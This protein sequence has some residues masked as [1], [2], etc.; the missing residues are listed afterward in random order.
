MEISRILGI[1]HGTVRRYAA[2]AEFPERAPHRRQRSILDPY[3]AHLEGRHADGCENALQLWRDIR[4]LGYT[5]TSTQV[6][7]WLQ[8]RRQ[9]PARTTPHQ[10]RVQDQPPVRADEP[11][12]GDV[13]AHVRPVV[14]EGTMSPTPPAVSLPSPRQLAWLL[15]RPADDLPDSDRRMLQ[16]LTQDR[17]AAR[18]VSFV[19]R[20]VALIRGRVADPE[21]ARA[22]FDVWL[23][24]TR[25]CG[26]RAVET[27]ARR[28]TQDGAAVRAALT[29]PWS[30]GQNGSSGH[31]ARAPQ[32]ANV[33]PRQ[34][35]LAPAPRPPGRLIHGKCGRP[36]KPGAVLARV[37]LSFARDACNAA[38]SAS[39]ALR[40]SNNALTNAT[41]ASGPRAHTASIS[42]RVIVVGTRHSKLRETHPPDKSRQRAQAHP[43]LRGT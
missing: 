37:G 8:Q 10:Y 3:L 7:R 41:I 34:L 5:G 30:N 15:V 1:A 20:F 14:S 13:P 39:S 26:I 21:G 33:R 28:L 11:W 43:A 29:T 18:V 25:T 17:E 12:S 16:Q 19:Q 35:R 38:I 31:E 9:R 36:G 40:R 23:D 27:F 32:T 42:S 22:A 6:R 4:D 2:A 24:E